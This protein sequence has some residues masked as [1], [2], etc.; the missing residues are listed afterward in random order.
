[1]SDKPL[2]TLE[3]RESFLQTTEADMKEDIW[4]FNPSICAVRVPL[5]SSF[6]AVCHSI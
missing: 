2:G 1:M 4:T 6:T 5:I 3:D